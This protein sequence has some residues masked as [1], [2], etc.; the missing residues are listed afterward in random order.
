MFSRGLDVDAR[1]RW[2]RAGGGHFMLRSVVTAAY[3]SRSTSMRSS[4]RSLVIVRNVEPGVPPTF[5]CA[6]LRV[7]RRSG[8][9]PD[10][11]RP[12]GG[13]EGFDDDG[14]VEITC[15]ASIRVV[16]RAAPHAHEECGC[17][18]PPRTPWRRA[19][20]IASLTVAP[21]RSRR[22]AR[23]LWARGE[24]MGRA[25]RVTFRKC[26]YVMLSGTLLSPHVPSGEA[27]A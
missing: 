8:R 22:R 16:G 1:L 25:R 24:G 2:K 13:D 6:S 10:L 11:P 17:R 14:A 15:A 9:G 19:H 20:R 27:T 12:P 4:T 26:R 18:A 3:S 5:P 23:L 7:R 21:P